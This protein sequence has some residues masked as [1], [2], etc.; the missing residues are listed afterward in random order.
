MHT[1]GAGGRFVLRRFL[2]AER[3]PGRG[4]VDPLPLSSQVRQL[5]LLSSH[6]GGAPCSPDDRLFFLGALALLK[7]NGLE[8]TRCPLLLSLK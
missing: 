7:L 5:S 6:P 1:I 3:C 8:R 2:G 4:R